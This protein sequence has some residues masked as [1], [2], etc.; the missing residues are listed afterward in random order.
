M[1]NHVSD[2]AQD[3][4]SDI[5]EIDDVSE[6]AGTGAPMPDGGPSE[7]WDDKGNNNPVFRTSKDMDKFARNNGYKKVQ[8]EKI[9]GQQVYFNKKGTPKYIVR[10]NTSH[11][12]DSIKGF[13]SIKD[14]RNKNRFGSYDS[15]FNK[16]NN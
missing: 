6:V 1:V 8:G 9:Q 7:D 13:N 10:S 4:V 16:V 12:G 15:N 14:I 2:S 11:H 3:D 5:P